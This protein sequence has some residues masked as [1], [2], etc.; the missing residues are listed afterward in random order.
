MINDTKENEVSIL[1][2]VELKSVHIKLRSDG[3]MQLDMKPY[4]GFTVNDLK[5][6]NNE[7]GILGEGK[8]FPNLVVVD[9]FLNAD[10]DVR[11]YSAS[12]ESLR[13]TIADAFVVKLLA[14]KFI[15]NFYIAF[16]KPARPTQIFNSQEE[17]IKWLKTFM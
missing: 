14:V 10:K 2:Q 1:K 6:I 8:A 7:I 9:H 15:G 12:E 11:E 5:E 3:I 17:A 13:Y 16:N 4:D